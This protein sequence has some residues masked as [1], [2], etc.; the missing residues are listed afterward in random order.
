MT[1]T[2]SSST[3]ARKEKNKRPVWRYAAL[4]LA[5]AVPVLAA[6]D[7]AAADVPVWLMLAVLGALIFCV[8]QQW[9]TEKGKNVFRILTTA[10]AGAAAVLAIYSCFF[11]P[12]WNS[13]SSR[14]QIPPARPLS[15]ELSAEDAREDIV[16]AYQTLL[17]THPDLLGFVPETLVQAADEAHRAVRGA[18]SLT[19]AEVGR[20][21]ERMASTLGD[22]HTGVQ[23]GNLEDVKYLR[24][25]GLHARRG[26]TLRTVNG[27]SLGDLREAKADLLS[28]E[29]PEWAELRLGDYVVTNAGLEFLDIP[30]ADV[31]YGYETPAGEMIMETAGPEDFVSLAVLHEVTETDFPP[32]PDSSWVSYEID[33]ERSLAV[34]SLD[35]CIN[36]PE[37]L[38]TLQEMFTQVRDL[39]IRNVAVDLRTNGGGDSS[40]AT[41]FIRYLDV[42]SYEQMGL[43]RRSGPLLTQFPQQTMTNEKYADLA[44][45]GDVYVLTSPAT[46]SSA[47]LF[48][49]YLC[50]N[51]LGTQIGEA[52]GN[53]ADG[54][55]EVATF[56]LPNSRL[57]L[58]V[59]TKRFGRIG[60]GSLL[61]PDIPV[62]AED[63]LTELQAR[64]DA[65]A[66]AE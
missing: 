59:S 58:G 49:E 44:F 57:A 10:A 15:E 23:L 36:A 54:C 50:D 7:A 46:F 53:I 35:E 1:R 39:G 24:T 29:T 22:A 34:L 5:A 47:M 19:V 18:D 37:Y 56:Q 43:E 55:G 66:P 60:S 12:Y 2:M 31:V 65:A 26:D 16:Y 32:D 25:S 42:D 33:P 21:V 63:A 40:V 64:L 3:E 41:E 13:I 9:R 27:V 61:Q 6:A 20:L 8:V 51:G 62:P 11:S 52:P 28:S 17:R 30:A 45:D 4:A 38:N 48:T 14:T